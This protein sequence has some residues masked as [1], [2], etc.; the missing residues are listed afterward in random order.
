MD[1]A[2]NVLGSVVYNAS[3][4]SFS[5]AVLNNLL[6]DV[7]DETYASDESNAQEC[8][9]A[10]ILNTIKKLLGPEEDYV[11]FDD[12]IILH[13]NSTLSR[14]CQLGVGPNPPFRITGPDEVWSDFIDE[15]YMEDIKQYIYLSVKLIFDPPANST[16]LSSMEATIDKLEWLLNS[17]AEV[18]Y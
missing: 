5:K 4:G 16:L 3:S 8:D 14:L 6:D 2:E 13:I 1:P 10:S 18:G 12:D 17:V 7:I 15:G 11:E 9:S